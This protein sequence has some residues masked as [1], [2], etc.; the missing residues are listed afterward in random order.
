[1]SAPDYKDDLVF[2]PQPDDTGDKVVCWT[3]AAMMILT[4]ITNLVTI[5]SNSQ[6]IDAINQPN[7]IV[8]K[9]DM[10]TVT[11]NC[12]QGDEDCIRQYW[13]DYGDD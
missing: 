6:V 10:V 2:S 13:D 11:S 4:I 8:S 5:L 1:M 7:V 12:E 3:L 9:C